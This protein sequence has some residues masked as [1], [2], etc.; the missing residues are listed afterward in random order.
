MAVWHAFGFSTAARR[1]PPPLPQ[2]PHALGM[3]SSAQSAPVELA[4]SAAAPGGGAAA[5]ATATTSELLHCDPCEKEFPNQRALQQHIKSHVVCTQCAFQAT[6][7]IVLEHSSTA[8]STGARW[9]YVSGCSRPYWRATSLVC[10]ARI[11][12]FQPV[13]GAALHPHKLLEVELV[14]CMHTCLHALTPTCVA[15]IEPAALCGC[16]A[17]TIHLLYGLTRQCVRLLP[18]ARA[19]TPRERLM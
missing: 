6:Q 18:R 7:S 1:A 16:N 4:A 3:S 15:G 14:S 2:V 11:A 10:R 12:S 13:R 17:F 5:A 9:A 19:R 8:H